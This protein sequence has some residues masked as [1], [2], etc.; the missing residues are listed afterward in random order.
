M[1]DESDTVAI[2]SHQG[3]SLIGRVIIHDNHIQPIISLAKHRIQ[4]PLNVTGI[5]KRG[6]SDR[7]QRPRHTYPRFLLGYILM[8][9][10]AVVCE[11]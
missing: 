1:L 8:N 10:S 3:Y 11:I 9:V 5:V 4:A 6:N 7:D 2:P